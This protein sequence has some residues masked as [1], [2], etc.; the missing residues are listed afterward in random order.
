VATGVGVFQRVVI[1]IRIPVPR[2]RALALFGDQA[3]GL[4]EAAQGGVIPSRVVKVQAEVG[5]VGVLAGVLV[6]GGGAAPIIARFAPGFVAQFRDD[7]AGCIGDQGGA[8][9]VVAEQVVERAVLAQ[10][11]ALSTG[12]VVLGNDAVGDFVVVADEVGGDVVDGLGDALAVAVVEEGGM[13]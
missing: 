8:A 7:V 1:D 13:I 10:G 12:V 9:Q 6:A 5:G 11:D 4:G 2:L 3:V